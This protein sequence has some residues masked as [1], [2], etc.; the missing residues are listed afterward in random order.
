MVIKNGV[1]PKIKATVQDEKERETLL[2]VC[3]S[4]LFLCSIVY[5]ILHKAYE[6]IMKNQQLDFEVELPSPPPSL[7]MPAEKDAISREFN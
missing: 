1:I 6:D 3:N 2:A 5:K 4:I 7:S